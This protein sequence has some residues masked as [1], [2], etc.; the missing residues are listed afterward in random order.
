MAMEEFRRI[1]KRKAD[2]QIDFITK[3]LEE[4]A[5]KSCN[6]KFEYKYNGQLYPG[7][8]DFFKNEGFVLSHYGTDSEAQPP[9]PYTVFH[10]SNNFCISK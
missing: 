4:A 2:E 10:L 6:G 9:N 1:I 7:V 5:E 3:E 8:E